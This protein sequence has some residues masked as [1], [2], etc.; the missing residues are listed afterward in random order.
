MIGDDSAADGFVAGFSQASVGDTT[1]NILGAWCDDGSGQQCSFENSTCGGTSQACHGRGPEFEKLDL[2]ISSCYEI[3][4]RQFEPALDLYR[5]FDANATPIRDSTVKAYHFFQDMEFFKFQ[6]NGRELQTCPAALGYSFA[7]GTS[8]WPGAFDFTQA[9][10]GAPSANPV[11]SVVSGVLRTPSQ[12]QRDCQQPKPI[13]LDVGEMSVPYAWTPNLVD[14]QMFRVG[15]MFFIVSPSEVT[16]MAGR[17]WKSA[18]AAAA[19]EQGLISG[20]AVVVVGSPANTYAHY[21]TTPEEYSIQRYEGASTLYGENQL[22]AFMNLTVS[23]MHYLAAAATSGPPQGTL[24]PDHRGNS[25]NFIQP[26]VLDSAPS[27]KKFGDV[28]K[29]PSGSYARGAVVNA[30]FVGANPRNNLRL[31]KTFVAV[32]R[33]DGN[34]WKVVRDDQDWFLSMTWRRTNT[35]LGTSS[36]EVSWETGGEGDSI[37]PGTYRLHYWGDSKNILGRVTAFEGISSTFTLT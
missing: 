5:D 10:S 3:G 31:E 24:P 4:K 12:E 25:L 34:V 20:D 8:D 36:V 37:Q 29:Q 32:E 11:W 23:N 2:G 6:H 9:D 14:I 26:V 22:P 28:L 21:V 7:A 33:Q 30:T 15:Q 16:T 27:G 18:I 1:P 13:L 35:I 17:R 19:T